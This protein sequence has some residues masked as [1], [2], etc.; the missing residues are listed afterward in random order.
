MEHA[1]SNHAYKETDGALET[2]RAVGAVSILWCQ[3]ALR[4]Q[5]QDIRFIPNSSSL[6][7]PAVLDQ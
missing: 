7:R 5:S 4:N 3:F 1:K 6:R 2:T